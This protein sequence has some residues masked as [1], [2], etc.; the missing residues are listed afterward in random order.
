[1]MKTAFVALAFVASG[2][3]VA[4]GRVIE[5]SIPR[6]CPGGPSWGKVAQCLARHGTARVV[7]S[8]GDVKLVR[9]VATD[10]TGWRMPG[11]YLYT[12]S[13]KKWRLTGMLQ[14]DTWDLVSFQRVTSRRFKGHRFD[15]K[16]VETDKQLSSTGTSTSLRQTM[17]VFCG[18]SL[19]C[20]TAITSCDFY[21]NGKVYWMFRG[22]LEMGKG[23]VHVR[24]DRS[25]AGGECEQEET[26]D[27]PEPPEP[28]ID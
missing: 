11:L 17:A 2:V 20:Q 19:P 8:Q 14:G 16:R 4:A 3:V 24:G 15:V 25:K 21:V 7:K 13:S 28:L 23:L 9:L 26:V 18:D 27:L 6:L 12:Q 10:D 22:T 5:P 1:M